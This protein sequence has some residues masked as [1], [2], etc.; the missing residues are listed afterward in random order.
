MC[1]LRLISSN[2]KYRDIVTVPANV[3]SAHT[4]ILLCAQA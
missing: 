2:Q 4:S 1:D 3:D